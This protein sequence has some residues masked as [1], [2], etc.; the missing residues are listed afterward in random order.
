[1]TVKSGKVETVKNSLKGR[2]LV[3]HFHSRFRS[4]D[5]VRF[6]APPE[7]SSNI[8]VNV[9]YVILMFCVS[10]TGLV[11][12]HHRCQDEC[13]F[14]SRLLYRLP[15]R[16][17]FRLHREEGMDDRKLVHGLLLDRCLH[18]CH[19]LWSV[20]HVD[21]RSL[22]VEETSCCMESRTCSF[23]HRRHSENHA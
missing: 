8:I 11:V 1:M 18:G 13:I 4:Q 19:L 20:L 9:G 6:L 14:V 10:S 23:L 3:I 2:E 5:I 21:E 22:Q 15:I 16:A 7:T 12:S 17:G